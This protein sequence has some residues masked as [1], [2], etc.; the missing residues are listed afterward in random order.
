[1]AVVVVVVAAAAAMKKDWVSLLV[2]LLVSVWCYSFFCWV[3]PTVPGVWGEQCVP[4]N[5]GVDDDVCAEVVNSDMWK[6]N[7]PKTHMNENTETCRQAGRC[8]YEGVKIGEALRLVE[9]RDLLTMML[10]FMMNTLVFCTAVFLRSSG[11]RCQRTKVDDEQDGIAEFDLDS[12]DVAPSIIPV[13]VAGAG[14]TTIK[15]KV[16][17]R[18]NSARSG[19]ED[20]LLSQGAGASPGSVASAAAFERTAS[21]SSDGMFEVESGS[22][23]GQ[24][25][26]GKGRLRRGKGKAAEVDDELD[27]EKISM[28]MMGLISIVRQPDELVY[29]HCGADAY[30]YM[31]YQK[32]MINMLWVM[33]LVSATVLLPNQ[34]GNRESV[35]QDKE[36]LNT[37]YL[38]ANAANLPG[39]DEGGPRMYTQLIATYFF[40]LLVFIWLTEFRKLMVKLQD[41]TYVQ[42]LNSQVQDVERWGSEDDSKQASLEDAIT[43]E[44]RSRTLMVRNVPVELSRTAILNAIQAATGDQL[45]EVHVPARC[46]RSLLSRTGLAYFQPQ[47]AG[48][49]I[50]FLTFRQRAHARTFR[51]SFKTMHAKVKKKQ[52]LQVDLGAVGTFGVDLGVELPTFVQETIDRV[53]DVDAHLESVL[54][55]IETNVVRAEDA[56]D[57]VTDSVTQV[58]RNLICCWPQRGATIAADT[59]ASDGGGGGGGLATLSNRTR[60]IDLTTPPVSEQNEDD[61]RASATRRNAVSGESPTAASARDGVEH[62]SNVLARESSTPDELARSAAELTESMARTTGGRADPDTIELKFPE[63]F[64]SKAWKVNWAPE[65]NDVVWPNLHVGGRE[66]KFRKLIST[67]VLTVAFFAIAYMYNKYAMQRQMTKLLTE[68]TKDT[69]GIEEGAMFDNSLNGKSYQFGKLVYGMVTIYA[70]VVVLCLVN[71][72]I[73]P[74]LC[75]ASSSLEGRRRNSSIHKAV[76]RRNYLF[77]MINILILPTLALKTPDAFMAQFKQMSDNIQMAKTYDWQIGYCHNGCL[78]YGASSFHVCDDNSFSTWEKLQQD[79]EGK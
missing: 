37:F 27:L 44:A 53:T 66:R 43:Q 21:N 55:E 13:A 58:F 65:R 25:P 57:R 23:G 74:V 77:M 20:D 51:D 73:L 36:F 69:T 61:L 28:E 78:C 40:S 7:F 68:A 50:A 24:S 79:E 1:V 15:N 6:S 38:W 33:F 46:G 48:S 31:K 59:S 9:D 8:N 17:S 32:Y 26:K 47:G 42:E 30:L 4:I 14:P 18:L 29:V 19:H 35:G 16:I 70:P 56:T 54:N 64:H 62:F 2:W 67:I 52:S 75:M 10:V 12:F 39:K 5:E 22:A 72:G 41:P 76:L 11:H 71:Y 3:G 49:G 34:Y 60:S 63:S 45:L